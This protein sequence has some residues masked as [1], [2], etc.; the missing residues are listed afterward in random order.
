MV[1]FQGEQAGMLEEMKAENLKQLQTIQDQKS[2]LNALDG[3]Y[4]TLK[5]KYKTSKNVAEMS[6]N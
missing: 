3:K 6:T 5:K 1:T 2:Q 4:K